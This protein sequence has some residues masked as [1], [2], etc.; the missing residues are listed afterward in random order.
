MR[1]IRPT[2]DPKK[3]PFTERLEDVRRIFL[4]LAEPLNIAYAIGALGGLR[5]GE[6]F[7]LRWPRD[8]STSASPSRGPSRTAT[9]ASC[10]SSTLC[11]RFSPSGN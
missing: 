8:A 4:A 3:T 10:R 2:H 7:A 1:L 5:T 11:C 6:V 9:P